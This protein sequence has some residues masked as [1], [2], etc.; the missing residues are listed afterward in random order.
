M[1][2]IVI[3]AD[4]TWQSPESD[5]ATHILRI[6]RGIAPEDDIGHKQV[7]FYDWGVGSDGNA[8]SGGITG[9]GIDRNILDAYRFLVHNYDEG[10]KLYLFGFSRGAYT[11]RSLAGLVANCGILRREHADKI[12]SA[13]SLYRRRSSAS[14]P[15][16]DL[17]ATF[18]SRFAVADLS[19]VHFVGVLD[20]V[21][22]L[23]IPAPFLGTLGS[24]RYLFHDT[25]PG[26]VITHARHAVSIDENRQDFEPTLW[27]PRGGVDLQQVWFAGVH[28]DIGGAYADR[29]LGDHAGQWLAREALACGLA[30]EPHFVDDL[31][32]DYAGP[33]HNEYKGFYRALRR[34]VVREIEPVVHISVRER[35]L[36]QSVRYPSPALSALMARLNGDW[37]RVRVVN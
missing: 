8:L 36:D 27:T 34:R 19:R 23:G 7:V 31:S 28:S 14:A 3:C 24:S 2:K 18:R 5:C 16:S 33:Q 21:G 10:D 25:D 35:W 6:A 37:S 26:Q 13:Y 17:S 29:T 1:K 4:G 15:G 20:T 11:V 9:K 22:A 12:A 30:F 32:P